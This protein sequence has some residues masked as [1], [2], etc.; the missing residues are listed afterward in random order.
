LVLISKESRR[1][2]TWVNRFMFGLFGLFVLGT[3]G[4]ALVGSV[5]LLDVNLLTRFAPWR[6]LHGLDI[7]TTNICRSDTV[8]SVMPSIAE[9]RSR[10]FQGDF[11]GWST[12]LVGGF[13]LAGFPKFGEFSPLSLPY[14][15]MPLWLAPAFVKLGELAVAIAGMILFLRRLRFSVASGIL[16]GIVFASSGFMISWTNWPQTRVAAFIPAFALGDRASRPATSGRGWAAN[17]S[18]CREHAAGRDSRGHGYGALLRR[19]VITSLLLNPV[20]LQPGEAMYVPAGVVHAYVHGMGVEI[21]ASSD[22][23]LRAGL[24]PKHVDVDE[25]LRTVDYAPAPPNRIAPEILHDATRVFHAPVDDFV[26]SVTTVDDDLVHPL[27][28]RGP[29]ILL[30]LN[31][32]LTINSSGD[33]KIPLGEH[34]LRKGESLFA[35]ASDGEL[36]ARGRGTLVQADVPL[37][38]TTA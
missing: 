35:P 30:C 11:P 29:K 21:M 17:G 20:S 32:D 28:G 26:L 6:A 19:V 1:G 16:A 10:L 22:N 5:T 13:P 27:P 4:Q 36:K 23:V 37:G 31:G 15:V 2:V 33:G 38:I 25:L 8:D 24:T 12:S 34:S 14:Y 7:L 3:L 18:R 9:I